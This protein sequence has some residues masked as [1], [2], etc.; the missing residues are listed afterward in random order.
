MPPVRL[1]PTVATQAVAAVQQLRMRDLVSLPPK[2]QYVI[3]KRT[4]SLPQAGTRPFKPTKDVPGRA[5][6]TPSRHIKRVRLLN[7]DPPFLPH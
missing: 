1:I 5:T 4:L 7:S 2:G 6:P 3:T